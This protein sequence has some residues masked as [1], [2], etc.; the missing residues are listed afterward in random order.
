M[1]FDFVYMTLAINIVDGCGLSNS[2]HRELLP[3]D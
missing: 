1:C 2:E 3:K